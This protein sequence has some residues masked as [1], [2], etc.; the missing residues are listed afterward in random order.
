[1]PDKYIN[2]FTDF[3]F[4][5]IFGEEENKDLL[6]DFIQTLL[7]E[8]SNITTIN[9]LKTEKLGRA[10]SERKAIFD[11]YCENDK[12]E[13]FIVELQRA[14]QDYF[15]ERS[16]YY[17]TFAIQEQAKKGKWDYNWQ[18]VYTI[19]I[20][21]FS[22]TQSLHKNVKTQVVLYDEE[23]KVIFSDKLKFIYLEM[24]KFNKNID[25]LTTHYE[26]W[27]FLLKN[28]H[29][30]DKVPNELR[31]K[32]FQKVFNVAEIAKYKPQDRQK[33]EDSL[34]HYRDMENSLEVQYKA[35]AKDTK[36]EIALNAIQEGFSNELIIKL[37]GLDIE[38]IEKLRT[39]DKYMK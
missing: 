2:P 22:F 9:Y 15:K 1:M 21:D 32:A 11:L 8:K 16:I 14:E 23:N 18:G 35:G 39:G 37:T 17:S 12:G 27:L 19:A 5:K 31:E 30:L 26:K 4:K 24:E 28:L 38:Q 7:P 6:I 34:K 36:K 25:E 13:K 29:L 33:Y 20:M 3:G 10:V